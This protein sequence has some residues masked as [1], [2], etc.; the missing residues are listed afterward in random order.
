[1]LKRHRRDEII[2]EQWARRAAIGLTDATDR[3]IMAVPT[4]AIVD[5]IGA[6]IGGDEEIA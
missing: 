3:S 1:L 2:L 4:T 5:S 6:L